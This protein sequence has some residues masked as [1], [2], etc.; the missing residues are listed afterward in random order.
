MKMT[1]SISQIYSKKRKRSSLL[2]VEGRGSNA[3]PKT[4]LEPFEDE[5]WIPPPEYKNETVNNVLKWWVKTTRDSGSPTKINPQTQRPKAE[6]L[7]AKYGYPRVLRVI[8]Y[9]S[10]PFSKYYQYPYGLGVVDKAVLELEAFL[11][12]KNRKTYTGWIGP[13]GVKDLTHEDK[14]RH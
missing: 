13:I 14:G 8:L 11:K 10:T 6:L 12:S 4:V 3:P 7:I 2:K 5:N 1:T 9:M